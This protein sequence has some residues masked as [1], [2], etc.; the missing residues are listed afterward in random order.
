GVAIPALHPDLCGPTALVMDFVDG[1]RFDDP[2]LDPELAHEAVAHTVRALYAMLFQHGLVH[3]DLH[4]GNV[5]LTGDGAVALLDFGYVA[6][7]TLAQQ[8]AFAKLFVAMALDDAASATAVIVDT[9]AKLPANLDRAALQVELGRHVSQASGVT[10]EHFSI[11][12]FVA[13][14]FAIQHRHGIVAA[15][16]FAMS[17]MALM[18]LEG[19][20]LQLAP[21]LDFQREA[22][23]FVL[24]RTALAA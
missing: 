21:Q 20:I 18:T 12:R 24:K 8:D 15:P 17:I 14:L 13:G 7:L 5:L 4:P 11:A 10:A 2:G 9:A 3:C 1:R 22:L 23:P 6:R 19:L 16:D